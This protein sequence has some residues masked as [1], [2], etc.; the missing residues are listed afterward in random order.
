M[1][2]STFN[3]QA[4]A[5]ARGDLVQNWQNAHSPA[6]AKDP[7]AQH[8]KVTYPTIEDYLFADYSISHP[9]AP[10]TSGAAAVAST[11]SGTAAFNPLSLLPAGIGLVSAI[12]RHKSRD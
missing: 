9:T 7:V 4:Y 5:A 10:T 12:L 11:T 1:P 6:F 8:I 2:P 3:A